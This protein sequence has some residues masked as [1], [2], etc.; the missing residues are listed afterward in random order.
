MD[1]SGSSRVRFGNDNPL[2]GYY[3]GPDVVDS[4]TFELAE[5]VSG[6]YLTLQAIQNDHFMIDEIQVFRF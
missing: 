4:H 6:Q 3:D 1:M 5:A 2:L